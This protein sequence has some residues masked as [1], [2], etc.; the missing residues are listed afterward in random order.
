MHN[1]VTPTST[2][3][4]PGTAVNEVAPSMVCRIKRNSCSASCGGALNAIPL[5]SGSASRRGRLVRQVAITGET[6]LEPGSCRCQVLC[7]AKKGWP[8]DRLPEPLNDCG[9]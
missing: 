6:Y 5:I 1:A 9:G 8:F 7:S 2:I 3:P 4:L